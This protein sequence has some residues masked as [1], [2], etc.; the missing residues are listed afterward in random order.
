[1]TGAPIRTF[2]PPWNT[3]DRNTLHAL[4][5]SGIGIMSADTSGEAI[6]EDGLKYLPCTCGIASVRGAV[7]RA[8]WSPEAEPVIVVVFHPHDIA[9]V[10]SKRGKLSCDEFIDLLQWLRSKRDI[11]LMSLSQACAVIGDLS[12][13]RLSLSKPAHRLSCKLYWR[14]R[15]DKGQYCGRSLLQNLRLRVVLFYSSI[16]GVSGVM[17]C[18]AV[19]QVAPAIPAIAIFTF[20][21]NVIMVAATMAYGFSRRWSGWKEMAAATMT[22]GAVIGAWAWLLSL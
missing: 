5:A 16:F 17:S 3:Y 15:I 12:A 11:S 21:G 14:L 8:R 4:K 18:V 1:M 9:E 6:A 2:I 10:N 19:A 7:K 22:V 20:C 13:R